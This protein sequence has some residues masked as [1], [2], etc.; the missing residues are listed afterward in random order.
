MIQES[1]IKNLLVM[2]ENILIN[3]HTSYFIKE[4]SYNPHNKNKVIL[5][6]CTQNTGVI[7]LRN[8]R[9]GSE[10]RLIKKSNAGAVNWFWVSR[11][12]SPVPVYYPFIGVTLYEHN[13][14]TWWKK[15]RN[16]RCFI[17]FRTN[18][19]EPLATKTADKHNVSW[20]THWANSAP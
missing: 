2:T 18:W 5:K 8:A 13:H 6:S 11:L 10:C 14:F 3:I 17:E 15:L 1:R 12:N 19:A 7:L 16:G 4:S 20:A 9:P